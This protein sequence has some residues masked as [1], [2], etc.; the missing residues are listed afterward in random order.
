[1]TRKP[2]HEHITEAMTASCARV[3][4]D[5]HEDGDL[6][7][8]DC[9]KLR[10]L[11]ADEVEAVL[12]PANGRLTF[13]VGCDGPRG[14][15]PPDVRSAYVNVLYLDADG[16]PA[17]LVSVR[18]RDLDLPPVTDWRQSIRDLLW[19]HGWRLDGY[20]VPD[21]P[22]SLTRLPTSDTGNRQPRKEP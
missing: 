22:S 9:D 4:A 15:R 13:A 14:N 12:D 16:R 1:M 21:D 17:P 5:A 6:T 8:A 10:E 18:I 2:L 19:Q 7:V 11:L 20:Q 3:L